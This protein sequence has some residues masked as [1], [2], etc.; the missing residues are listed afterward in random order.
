[1]I[2]ILGAGGV[3]ARELVKLLSARKQPFRLVA[4][5]ARPLPGATEMTSADLSEP[6][7][8]TMRRREFITFLGGAIP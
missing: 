6:P 2:T 7:G 1:M 4:R 8:A 5:H 3:I